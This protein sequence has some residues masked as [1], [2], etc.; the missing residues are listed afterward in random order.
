MLSMLP[1]TQQALGHYLST[2]VELQKKISMTVFLNFNL[3]EVNNESVE[4]IPTSQPYGPQQ[5]V[6]GSHSIDVGLCSDI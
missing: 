1:G 3:I 4:C 5:R 2:S 6:G